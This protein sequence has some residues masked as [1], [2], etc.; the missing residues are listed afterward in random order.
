MA[1]P[2]Y[3]DNVSKWYGSGEQKVHVLD[4]LN[5]SVDSGEFVAVLGPSGCGKTT[6]IKMMDGLVDISEGEI[7]IGDRSVSEPSTDVAMVF[8]TFQLYPWRSVLDNVALG[9][10]IQGVPKS[11]RYERAREWIETVGL[12]RFE[13]KYPY[14][15]SGGMQ[16]RVGLSRALVVDPE[17]LL[18]DEPFGALDAQTK[19]TL[20]TELLR[21]L[22]EEQKTVV[23]VTHD[24]REAV[25]LADRVVVLDKIPTSITM[26][27]DIEF[28]RPRWNRRGE[29]EGTKQFAEYEQ[30]LR[31]HLGLSE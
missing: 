14:E 23:F 12:S 2:I 27:L 25:F 16:Q 15:L 24:I 1:L 17:V 30:Q 29:V 20:Q 19:D 18:M 4:Q 5:L 22:D 8:Q 6:L 28:D 31:E 10:E 7:R 13:D 26:E 3:A 21:L 9:L 11:E